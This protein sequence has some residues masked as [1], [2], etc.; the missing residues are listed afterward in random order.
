MNCEKNLP[1]LGVQNRGRKETIA[2]PFFSF[3]SVFVA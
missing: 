3:L 2:A 1:Q